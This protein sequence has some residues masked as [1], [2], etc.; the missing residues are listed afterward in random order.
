MGKFKDYILSIW[1]WFGSNNLLRVLAVVWLGAL[2]VLFIV[3]FITFAK[4]S[5][6]D[7]E[8]QAFWSTNGDLYFGAIGILLGIINMILLYYIT[9]IFHDEGARENKKLFIYQKR[10]EAFDKFYEHFNAA[11]LAGKSYGIIR[12]HNSSKSELGSHEI[13]LGI[14]ETLKS[15]RHYELF[16]QT[17]ASRYGAYFKYNFECQNYKSVMSTAKSLYELHNEFH[18]SLINSNPDWDDSKLRN[19]VLEHAKHADEFANTL[20]LEIKS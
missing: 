8:K 10:V 19:K 14:S 15:A 13:I 11:L 4:I 16:L 6:G 20:R 2:T 17:F 18:M 1:S 9:R 5:E 12:L 3:P 7:I